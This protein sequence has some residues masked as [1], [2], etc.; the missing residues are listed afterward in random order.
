MSGNPSGDFA[1][2]FTVSAL[3]PLRMFQ[4]NGSSS[5]AAPGRSIVSYAWTFSDGH[6]EN[7]PIIDHDFGAPGTY[8]VTLTV[9]DDI[10]QS[11]FKTALVVAN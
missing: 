9:T 7:G 3:G 11:A 2:D 1:A 10:G 8:F 4:F 6:A 5:T